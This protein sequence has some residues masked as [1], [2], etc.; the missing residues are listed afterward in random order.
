MKETYFNRN[1]K[2]CKKPDSAKVSKRFSAYGIFIQ[3]DTVL[4]IKNNWSKKFELPGGG[5]KKNETNL[6]ALKREVKEETGYTPTK[7][8]KKP[9]EILKSNFY[10]DD[11]KKYF[12]SKMYFFKIKEMKKT[13]SKID[14]YEIKKVV[15]LP[16]KKI[17]KKTVKEKHFKIILSSLE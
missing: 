4:L 7:I 5:K 12:K 2:P 15:F 17:S 9:I 13:E 8:N 3:N 6:Q 1:N 11:I 14:S 16:I 10:A